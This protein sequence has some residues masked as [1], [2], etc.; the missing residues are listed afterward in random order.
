M[1]TL[2]PAKIFFGHDNG[3]GVIYHDDNVKVTATENSHFNFPPGSPAYD[4]YKSY[5]YRF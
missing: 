5:S 2:P 3:I 4:K 1:R